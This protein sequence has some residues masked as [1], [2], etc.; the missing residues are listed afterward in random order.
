MN[1]LRK[2]IL[3]ISILISGIAQAQKGN[4]A[5]VNGLNMY[6]EIHGEKTD[7]QPILLLH[8]AYATLSLWGNFITELSKSRQ[9]IALDFQGHG[10]TP[11]ID[12]PITYEHLADDV[13]SLI[14]HLNLEKADVFGYSMGGAVALQL[15][16]RHPQLINKMV[17]A[18]ASYRSEDVYPELSAMIG[19]MKP[20]YMEG[21][22][23]K[24]AYDS[25]SPDPGN[26]P[27]LMEKLIAL[28]ETPQN[29]AAEDIANIPFP[30]LFINGDADIVK[31]EHTVE[32]YR[33]KDGGPTPDFMS[34]SHSQL[35][36]LPGTTHIGV[37]ERTDWLLAMIP[38][39]LDT[40]SSSN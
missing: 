34:A 25:L 35:A 17:A 5:K 23:F 12:R 33:L 24:A 8:G 16:I 31:P 19:Q 3:L 7:T 39:F 40:K 26:F 1:S 29:W 20:E 21:T 4:Y 28:D 15:G 14:K 9:V 2:I 36:I 18:S 37:M 27:V 30:I 32:M 10:R 22:P 38:A 11:D 13:F 6:Y